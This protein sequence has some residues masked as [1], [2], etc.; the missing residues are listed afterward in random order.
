MARE[1]IYKTLKNKETGEYGVIITNSAGEPEMATISIPQLLSS[2][3]TMNMIIE[4][5]STFLEFL[6]HLEKFDLRVVILEE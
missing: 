2:T 5:Y 6:T 4:L 1:T 3:A